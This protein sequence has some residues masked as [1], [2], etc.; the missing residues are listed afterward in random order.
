MACFGIEEL[1]GPQ[2][3]VEFTLRGVSPSFNEEIL[4]ELR[5]LVRAGNVLSLRRLHAR[6]EGVIDPSRRISRLVVI[7][8]TDGAKGLTGDQ[9]LSGELRFSIWGQRAGPES[10]V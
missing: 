10:P 7:A 5:T 9:V 3:S 4:E 6:T 8:T 1:K 2:R